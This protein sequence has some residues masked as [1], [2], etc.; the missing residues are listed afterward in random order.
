M[1]KAGIILVLFFLFTALMLFRKGLL[2]P[3]KIENLKERIF[4]TLKR[5]SSDSFSEKEKKVLPQE[6]KIIQAL[7]N[8]EEKE[9]E[10]NQKKEELERLREHLVLQEKELEERAS[11]LSSLKKEIEDYLKK[12]QVERDTKMKWL[13]RVYEEM[14]AEEV[15]SIIERLDDELSLEILSQMSE[16]Q[17][18]KILGAMEVQKAA[19]LAQKIGEEL[20]KG[21]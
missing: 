2:E 6:E 12:A 18:G 11:Q 14:Q 7:E 17:V 13:A 3:E 20:P 15:A 16:R 19:K 10:I 9:K 21:K 8:V 5:E 1:K 4:P